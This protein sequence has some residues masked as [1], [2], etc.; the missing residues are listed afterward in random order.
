[1]ASKQKLITVQSYNIICKSKKQSTDEEIQEQHMAYMAQITENLSPIQYEVLTFEQKDWSYFR[2]GRPFPK[3]FRPY[4]ETV[5]PYEWN[6]SDSE[7][8]A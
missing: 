5:I 4:A 8:A 2:M 3:P 7:V 1:M 6:N